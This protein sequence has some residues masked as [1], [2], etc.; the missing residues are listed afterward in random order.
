MDCVAES[1]GILGKMHDASL[2]LPPAPILLKNPL[3][4]QL[5]TAFGVAMKNYTT[6]VEAHGQ[7]P[8]RDT[9][10]WKTRQNQIVTRFAQLR[11][12]I[13][14]HPQTKA[15]ELPGLLAKFTHEDLAM[16]EKYSQK[17]VEVI[18]VME[19]VSSAL[20][21]QA[22]TAALLNKLSRPKGPTRPQPVG[23]GR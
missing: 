13:S 8:Q 19:C 9:H 2:Q 16:G 18:L 7:L 3:L 17:R 20:N 1:L 11:D 14:K 23:V 12:H 10:D 15:E 5:H 4:V 6:A 22:Q 21:I